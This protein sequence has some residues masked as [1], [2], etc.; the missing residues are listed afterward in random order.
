LNDYIE[1]LRIDNADLRSRKGLNTK[2]PIFNPA[3]QLNFDPLLAGGSDPQ[4]PGF[5]T[6]PPR[7]LAFPGIA[8]NPQMYGSQNSP[9]AQEP[10]SFQNKSGV[11][12]NHSR[13]GQPEAD[14]QQQQS[15]QVYIVNYN[16]VDTGG[17]NNKPPRAHSPELSSVTPPPAPQQPRKVK[18][19][20]KR[21][22]RRR[23]NRS[24]KDDENKYL[25][26]ITNSATSNNLKNGQNHNI[27]GK[28]GSKRKQSEMKT[29]PHSQISGGSK[30][31][32]HMSS[33]NPNQ[34]SPPNQQRSLSTLKGL[35]MGPHDPSLPCQPVIPPPPPNKKKNKRNYYRKSKG[36]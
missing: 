29:K 5:Q 34:Q 25:I 14:P 33:T 11:L 26:T 3:S 17:W 2:A 35:M 31:Y 30:K 1:M 21:R 32:G 15:D 6:S 9:L 12:N 13:A 7:T 18:K 4:Q 22:S 28:G 36:K 10:E 16:P 8:R 24:E 27:E 20:K 23:A 19:K